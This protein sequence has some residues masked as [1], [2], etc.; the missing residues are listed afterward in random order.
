[1]LI[2]VI[3]ACGGYEYAITV[4]ACKSAATNVVYH[5]PFFG[6]VHHKLQSLIASG[7]TPCVSPMSRG[8]VHGG[9][10][11]D[12]GCLY[13][14]CKAVVSGVYLFCLCLAPSVVV[15]LVSLVVGTKVASSLFQSAWKA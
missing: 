9:V 15:A 14:D 4:G 5:Y 13:V 10:A 7:H 8:C 6:A 1:M 12:V 2:F 11:A 3:P